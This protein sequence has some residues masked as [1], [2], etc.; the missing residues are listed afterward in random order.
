MSTLLLLK[1]SSFFEA[2]ASSFLQPLR[3]SSFFD[4]PTTPTLQLQ[5]SRD[6]T[7]ET[8]TVVCWHRFGA[9][10][11]CENR[12]RRTWLSFRFDGHM[13][14]IIYVGHPWRLAVNCIHGYLSS[15]ALHRLEIQQYAQVCIPT[16]TRNVYH[17]AGSATMFLHTSKAFWRLRRT[18]F[19]RTRE[20]RHLRRGGS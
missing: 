6:R 20:G 8:H 12:Y 18:V 1:R 14:H 3:R 19:H 10:E 13:V 7:P 2:P 16:F 9:Q 15:S 11:R 4:T 17:M 5:R